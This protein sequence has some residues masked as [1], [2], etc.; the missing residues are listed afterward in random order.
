MYIK[1]ELEL[2]SYERAHMNHNQEVDNILQCTNYNWDSYAASWKINDYNYKEV[3]LS[4]LLA[5]LSI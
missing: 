5:S 3:Y 1:V 2:E 4:A